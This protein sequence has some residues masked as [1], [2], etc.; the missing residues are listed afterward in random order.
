MDIDVNGVLALVKELGDKQA[1]IDHLKESKEIL[2]ISLVEES[3]RNEQL[4]T[5]NGDLKQEIQHIRNGIFELLPELKE[6]M[7][8]SNMQRI[9][10]ILEMTELKHLGKPF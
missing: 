9:M 6:R 1:C 8:K 7:S 10:Y 2:K 4:Y 5:E 3:G